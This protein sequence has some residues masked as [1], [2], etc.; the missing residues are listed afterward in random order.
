MRLRNRGAVRIEDG[1]TATLARR[2]P[3]VAV[4]AIVGLI[5]VPGGAGAATFSNPTPITIP[6]SGKA[7]PYPSTIAVTGLPGTV[8]NARATLIGV[9]HTFPIDI[10]TLLVAP[11]GQRTNLMSN[12]CGFDTTPLTGQT[13]TFDDAASSFLPADDQ[14][15][16]GTYKPTVEEKPKFPAP[17]PPGDD[18][19]PKGAET[20]AA[21]SALNGSAANGT[22]QLFVFD[23]AGSDEG[24]I[25]GGWSLELLTDAASGACKGRTATIVGTNG[26]DEIVGTDDRDVIAALDGNDEVSGLEGND[27]ICGNAGRDELR[28]GKGKDKLFGQKGRDRLKGQ[29]G[30]DRLRGGKGND[31]CNGGRGDDSAS[32]CEV[33]KSI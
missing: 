1:K 25:A 14:C 10:L 27:V 28:G 17:A 16:S 3:L 13:F 22:W 6:D 11:N 29:K 30:K 21:M 7:T 23:D 12:V 9:S 26:P 18:G 15:V 8:T 31:V 19:P 5:A 4:A 2:F 20:T 33:E 32:K 24:A